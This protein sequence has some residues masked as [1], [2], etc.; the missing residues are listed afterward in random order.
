M[1][2]EA[3]SFK[4]HEYIST[5]PNSSCTCRPTVYHTTCI[6]VQSLIFNAYLGPEQ[7]EKPWSG[8][9]YHGFMT[10]K[11]LQH[12]SGTARVWYNELF[13]LCAIV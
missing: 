11:R 10:N 2:W 3:A 7:S 9:A 6:Y 13:R 8:T 12:K 5:T 4:F 1:N